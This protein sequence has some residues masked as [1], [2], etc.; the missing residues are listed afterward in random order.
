MLLPG[1][2]LLAVNVSPLGWV[3]L[4]GEVGYTMS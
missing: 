4:D 3:V 2:F 1:G